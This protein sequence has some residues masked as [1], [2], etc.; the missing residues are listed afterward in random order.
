[1]C[2][3]NFASYSTKYQ[4]SRWYSDKESS[5]QC[6][7]SRFNPWVTKIPWSRKW[8]LTLIFLP[9]KSHGHRTLVGYCP[10]NSCRVTHDWAHTHTHT[11]T[12]TRAR[13]RTHTHTQYLSCSLQC[14][15]FSSVAQLCLTLG[16]PMD[17]PTPVSLS[18]SN[19][20]SLLK[21]MPMSVTHAI[22]YYFKI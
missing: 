19:S 14:F 11:H 12:H 20:R 18:I 2:E 10:W 15:Q 6:K 1:M 7:R 21:F 4:T 3:L 13:V 5:C 16:D 17:C 9:G 8:Q 22:F